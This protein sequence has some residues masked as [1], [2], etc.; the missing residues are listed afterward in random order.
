MEA[1]A[2]LMI[3]TVDLV[4]AEGRSLRQS[5]VRLG[6]AAALALV[7]LLVAV[8]GVVFVL[9]GIYRFLATTMSEPAAAVTFGVLA[10]A[11]AGG[12]TWWARSVL[13]R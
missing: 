12:L 1:L 8:F 7:A 4:E 9:L 6:V 11:A 2:N 10:L 3:A 13:K 5:I